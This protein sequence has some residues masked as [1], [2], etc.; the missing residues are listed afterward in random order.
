MENKD[1]LK[2]CECGS[3]FF[4]EVKAKTY[5]DARFNFYGEV[6]KANLDFEDIT[7]PVAICIFCGKVHIPGTSFS[8]MNIMNRQVQVYAELLEQQKKRDEM[9]SAINNVIQEIPNVQTE[10]DSGTDS[11]PTIRRGKARV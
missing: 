3:I 1:V 10:Q 8:G 5:R 4:N 2:T 11:K 7:V 6:T 9:F